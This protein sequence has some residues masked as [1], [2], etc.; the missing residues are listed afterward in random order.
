MQN[1]AQLL[2]K[3]PA[4]I[5]TAFG[6]SFDTGEAA[7]SIEALHQELKEKIADDDREVRELDD[8][9]AKRNRAVAAWVEAYQGTAPSLEG[10]YRLAGWKELAERVLPTQRTIRGEHPGPEI[11]PGTE[12]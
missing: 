1:V 12:D 11:E 2:K 5:K 4:T 9:L 3:S 6:V 10:L 7:A 8:A